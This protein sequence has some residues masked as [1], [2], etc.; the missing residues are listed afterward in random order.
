[1]AGAAHK[2]E[3]VRGQGWEGVEDRL[4]LTGWTKKRRVIVLRRKIKAAI[5]LAPSVEPALAA[6]Q[7][8]FIETDEGAVQY[9]YMVLVTSLT[10]PIATLAQ[11]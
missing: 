7:L 6:E 2:G 9:E 1:L 11:H 10:E 4:Q 8:Q 3:S 5:A